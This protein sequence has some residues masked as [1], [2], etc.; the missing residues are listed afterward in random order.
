[1]SLLKVFAKL[2]EG[3]LKL[4]LDKCEFLKKRNKVSGTYLNN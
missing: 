1:M 4:Q 3:N 2:K